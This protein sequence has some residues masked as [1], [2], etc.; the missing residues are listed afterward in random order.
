MAGSVHFSS[1]V[2]LLP[3]ACLCFAGFS[4]ASFQFTQTIYKYDGQ[5]NRYFA[6]IIAFAMMFGSLKLVV[7]TALVSFVAAAPTA[8]RTSSDY[9]TECGNTACLI[10]NTHTELS[11]L[12][13]YPTKPRITFN[14]N[15]TFKI[16]VFSDLHF[17]ENP[18]DAW[19]PQQD[20]NSTKLMRLVLAT[21]KPDYA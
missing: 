20:V 21:E 12:D 6:T 8:S 19:G 2:F 14:S 7:A 16:T 5:F 10:V 18:W 3:H 9:I 11:A 17:G 15:G 4:N 1:L 13:P